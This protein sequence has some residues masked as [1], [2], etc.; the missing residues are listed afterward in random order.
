MLEDA[1]QK[2]NRT[3]IGMAEVVCIWVVVTKD[4]ALKVSVLLCH[5]QDTFQE[6]G[7]PVQTLPT[8]P[9]QRCYD[10]TLMQLLVIYLHKWQLLCI[11]CRCSS[12]NSRCSAY[13]RTRHTGLVVF[14]AQL[15]CLLH[16]Q[17]LQQ[18]NNKLKLK[19]NNYK[20]K[21]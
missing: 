21:L 19:L 7:T 11:T 9:N 20:H 16:R 5:H 2:Q 6:G 15:H 13:C 17:E 4:K 10:I 14:K 18:H 1:F 3:Q 12:T 8:V